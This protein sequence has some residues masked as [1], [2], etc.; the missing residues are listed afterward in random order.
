MVA[1]AQDPTMAPGINILPVCWLLR[2]EEEVKIRD[3]SEWG[4]GSEDIEKI[5]PSWNWCMI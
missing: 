2:W 3:S 1:Y 4:K 5:L